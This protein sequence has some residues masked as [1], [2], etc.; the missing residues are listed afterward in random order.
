M[1]SDIERPCGPIH[2]AKNNA[3]KKEE[4]VLLALEK[5]C[6]KDKSSAQ[7]KTVKQLCEVLGLPFTDPKTKE[8]TY[9]K[10]SCAGDEKTESKI[11]P[12]IK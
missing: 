11:S 2:N 5:K 3:F 12:K 7:R 9:S 6:F 4:L 8:T 10:S 1:S